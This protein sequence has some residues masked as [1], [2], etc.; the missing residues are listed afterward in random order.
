MD[1]FNETQNNIVNEPCAP[2]TETYAP[3]ENNV[4]KKFDIKKFLL[5]IIAVLVIA[6][7]LIAFVI[8]SSTAKNVD[9][10]DVELELRVGQEYQLNYIIDPAKFADKAEWRIAGGTGVTVDQNGVITAIAPTDTK[11][12]VELKAGRKVDYVLVTVLSGPDFAAIFEECCDSGYAEVAGDGSYL[13]IDT[14]PKNRDDYIDYGAYYAIQDV[15]EILELPESLW[16]KMKKTRALDGT[17]VQEYEDLGIVVTWSYHPDK[18]LDVTYE[19][20]R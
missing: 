19:A 10:T 17:Q 8:S 1:N 6:G 5:P 7:L 4:N 15:H 14:N 11:V 13:T 20:M 12:Q 16:E 18:G 2:T 9:I 3:V